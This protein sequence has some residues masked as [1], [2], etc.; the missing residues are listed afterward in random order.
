[1]G[2]AGT[3][4][5]DAGEVDQTPFKIWYS[6]V[7]V[8]RQRPYWKRLFT[9]KDWAYAGFLGLAHV[10]CLFAPATFSWH[11]LAVSAAL[12]VVTG[13]LGI[14]L[15]YHRNLSHKSFKL[16]KWL[17]YTFAYCGVQAL[18][19]DPIEWV[20]GHRYHHQ[21]CD[22]PDDPHTPHE[23]FWHSHAGWLLDSKAT[24]ARAGMRS[25]CADMERQPFY[26]WIEETYPL[27][28]MASAVA[29][30]AW[31][32][33]PYVVWGLAVRAVWVW[34]ITW[35]VNSVSHVWGNQPWKTGDESR[36]NWLIGILA[37]GEGWHNNHHAFEFS[38][39]HGLKWWQFDPTWYTIVA[40]KWLGLA[41]KIQ[42]PRESQMARLAA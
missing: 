23:G 13:M 24:D 20:S 25:N 35:A 22:T 39:R 37:F 12:Y 42:L 17:E 40:L 9:G 3:S 28:I 15:S 31:G 27:H 26:R 32:G 5:A 16:P 41:T 30:Y 8:V 29:L 18:Q 34:H 7:T 4:S 14:T 6:D 11:A 1:V 2:R 21:F 36:N 10:L 19:G 38:A 33:F